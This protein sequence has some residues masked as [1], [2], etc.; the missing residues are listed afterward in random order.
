[1]SKSGNKIP[2]TWLCYSIVLNNIYCET[3]WLFADRSYKHYNATWVY[4]I[5]DWQHASQ[6]IYTHDTSVQHIEAIKIRCLWAKNQ[7]IEKE[8][9]NQISEEAAYWRSVLERIIRIIL[10][11]T[12]GNNALR[13]SEKKFNKDNSFNEGNFL[14]TVRLMANY[15]HIL[16]K[17]ISCEESKVKYLSHTI[18]DELIIILSNNLLKTICAE[19]NG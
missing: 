6:K 12:A 14:Q 4:G 1:M 7:V 13:G 16:S 17:L 11:L 15:D 18:T 5:D 8:L 2:R 3:C 10:H 19:I 9:E